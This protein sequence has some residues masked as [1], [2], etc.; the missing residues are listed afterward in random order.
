MLFNTSFGDL[1]VERNAFE[2]V[3]KFSGVPQH[4]RVPFS[5]VTRFTD[6][7][8]NMMLPFSGEDVG[9]SVNIGDEPDEVDA[10]ED[11]D[12][13]EGTVISLDAFRRK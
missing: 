13:E 8:V 6:P 1:K 4:L 9:M 10:S 5:A 12:G 3:L 2:V 7:S 11:E